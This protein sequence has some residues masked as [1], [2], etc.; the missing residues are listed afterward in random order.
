MHS[1]YR[2]GISRAGADRMYYAFGT[3]R[4]GRAQIALSNAL[5]G[6]FFVND[7]FHR[8]DQV[9]VLGAK[10]SSLSWQHRDPVWQGKT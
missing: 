3:E 5:Y 4:Y 2:W 8:G 6:A 7:L 9:M 10:G 1:L